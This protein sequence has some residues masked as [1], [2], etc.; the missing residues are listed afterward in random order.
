MAGY[1]DIPLVIVFKKTS[2]GNAILRMK[3][4]KHMDIDTFLNPKTKVP[5]IPDTAVY[6]QIGTGTSFEKKWKEKYNL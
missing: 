1:L 6:I 5:G 4:I 2:R 3:V